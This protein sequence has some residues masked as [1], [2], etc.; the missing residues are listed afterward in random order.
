MAF[1]LLQTPIVYMPI[2]GASQKSEPC[3]MNTEYKY[4]LHGA[5]RVVDVFHNCLVYHGMLPHPQKLTPPE[6]Q[7]L[8]RFGD[9]ELSN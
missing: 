1:S 8:F 4:S 7:H 6:L 9:P 2:D 3:I 5:S